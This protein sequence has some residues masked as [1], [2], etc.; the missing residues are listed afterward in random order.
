[1]SSSVTANAYK[2]YKKEIGFCI[3]ISLR[4]IIWTFTIV[5]FGCK[6]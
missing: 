6:R 2:Y 4:M 3:L 5:Y 1:M